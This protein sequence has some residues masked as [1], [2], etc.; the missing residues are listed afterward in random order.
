[1]R[2]Q[3]TIARAADA[4]IVNTHAHKIRPATFQR[5]E[6]S[7]RTDPTPTIAPVI[8]WVVET[9]IPN[10]AAPNNVTAPAASAAKPPIGC[11]FVILD[12]IV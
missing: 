6:R 2:T 7:R 10:C 3:N 11:S 8:V 1:M 12:P 9:G 5:T 4:G